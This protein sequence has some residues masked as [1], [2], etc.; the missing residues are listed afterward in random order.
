VVLVLA[1]RVGYLFPGRRLQVAARIGEALVGTVDLDWL[2]ETPSSILFH[3]PSGVLGASAKGAR[4]DKKDI[5]YT[6]FFINRPLVPGLR[7]PS[8]IS[9][10]VRG[11]R[12]GEQAQILD[13]LFGLAYEWWLHTSDT[14]ASVNWSCVFRRYEC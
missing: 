1:Q 13:I 4:E 8:S 11:G 5:Q 2:H 9:T 12:G 14:I 10:A 7:M 3:I 6:Q